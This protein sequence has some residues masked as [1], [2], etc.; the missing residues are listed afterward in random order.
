MRGAQAAGVGFSSLFVADVAD[1]LR[2]TVI[3]TWK[4]LRTFS[5]TSAAA[6]GRRTLGRRKCS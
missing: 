6:V 1:A 2:S 5:E 4:S 3:G